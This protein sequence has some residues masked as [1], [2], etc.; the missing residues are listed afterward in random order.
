MGAHSQLLELVG[1][2]TAM[3]YRFDECQSPQACPRKL[4]FRRKSSDW[5]K[6]RGSQH[7]DS[8]LGR[9][10]GRAVRLILTAGHRHDIVAAPELVAGCTGK[11]ILADKAYDSD[12]FR[13]LLQEQELKGCIPPKGNR[14]DPASYHKGHY[15]RRHQVENFFRRIREKRAVST[16]YEKLASRYLD[17]LTLAAICDWLH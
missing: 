4:R 8:C 15:R 9:Y 2:G 11:T 3:E 14:T 5:Q 12:E 6:P 7:K 16:R 10:P 13:S 17:L 1:Q